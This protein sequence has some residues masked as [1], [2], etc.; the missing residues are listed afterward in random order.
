MAHGPDDSSLATE[1]GP[2]TEKL[3]RMELELASG[4]E[5]VI[6]G[7]LRGHRRGTPF[8]YGIHQSLSPAMMRALER[9]YREAG[10]KEAVIR[11]GETGASIMILTPDPE[12]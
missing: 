2:D 6:D 4:L 12:A 3:N 1:L 5:K 8:V 10:W 9:R 7:V 11:P